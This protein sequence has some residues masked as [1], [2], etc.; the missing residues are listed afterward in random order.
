MTDDKFTV[1]DATYP[2]KILSYKFNNGRPGW[3]YRGR[4]ATSMRPNPG[5]IIGE[6]DCLDRWF[7]HA[8]FGRALYCDPLGANVK[9]ARVRWSAWTDD[10][11]FVGTPELDTLPVPG[12]IVRIQ[13]V[14]DLLTVQRIENTPTE[15]KVHGVRIAKFAVPGWLTSIS[16]PS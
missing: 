15:V 9:L 1:D 16:N 12:S 13:G 6:H 14:N 4:A 2:F 7:V 3:F 10:N 11:H 8:A 5:D